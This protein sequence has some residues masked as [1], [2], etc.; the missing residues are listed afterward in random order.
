MLVEMS[1]L[2][3]VPWTVW[4]TL[5]VLSVQ[6]STLDLKGECFGFVFF[7]SMSLM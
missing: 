5:V 7:P 3:N 1:A 6:S 4:G 2:G